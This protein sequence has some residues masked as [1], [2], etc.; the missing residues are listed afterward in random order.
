MSQNVRVV[1]AQ[2]APSANAR[3]NLH[4]MTGVVEGVADEAPDV[5]VFPEYSSGFIPGGGSAM[6][7]LAE[8]LGGEFVRGLQELSAT[9]GGVTIVAGALVEDQGARNTIVAVGPD[10][11][12]ARAE[13]IH[14]YDAFGATESTWL[15]QGRLGDVEVLTI[16]EHTLGF[17][18]CY[19]LR[20]PEVA[21]RL[22]DAGATAIVVPAQ[23]VPGPH[24]I[25]H[26][27][28]LLRARAIESQCFVI[29]AGHPSPEGIGHSQIIAPTGEVLGAL[30]EEPGVAVAEL[31]VQL[32]HDQ[33]AAN[34]MAKARRL[35]VQPQL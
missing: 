6:A 10:G 21:R 7:A 3:E 8:P 12:L 16:G 26:W 4:A 33:R 14:L 20:F 18:A 35:S 19:D 9:H 17:M 1:V 5:V 31:D 25:L 24:K 13:K 23:W 2:Y 11:V 22:V 30:G 15:E 32:V 27:E 34:P 29:A 28:T